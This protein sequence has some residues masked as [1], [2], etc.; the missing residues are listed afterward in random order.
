MDQENQR[1][2]CR[3]PATYELQNQ[4]ATFGT[5]NNLDNGKHPC[6]HVEI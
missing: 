1:L 5:I 3:K 6:I 4:I 2:D